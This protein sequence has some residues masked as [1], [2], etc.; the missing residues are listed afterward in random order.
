MRREKLVPHS[1]EQTEPKDSMDTVKRRLGQFRSEVTATSD[2]EYER[3]GGDLLVTKKTSWRWRWGSCRLCRPP[4]E[5]QRMVETR[6]ILDD[7]FGDDSI[8]DIFNAVDVQS[9]NRTDGVSRSSNGG[10]PLHRRANS[11]RSSSENGSPVP[12]PS[13]FGSPDEEEA[14]RV[15]DEVEDAVGSAQALLT[16]RRAR[17]ETDDS[18]RSF[19]SVSSGE[20]ACWR[21]MF[22][23]YQTLPQCDTRELCCP[24]TRESWQ[25]IEFREI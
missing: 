22:P 7:G 11:T 9:A 1:C 25:E 19:D 2:N 17:A 12:P 6:D 15:L 5:R 20:G 8:S 4:S 24:S 16:R 14:S 21:Q 10:T 13:P 23:Y 3:S 18:V